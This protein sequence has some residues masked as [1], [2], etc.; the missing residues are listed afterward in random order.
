MHRGYGS[1]ACSPGR[2]WDRSPRSV[3]CRSPLRVFRQEESA[4]REARERS[5]LLRKERREE[6]RAEARCVA[7]DVSRWTG[8]EWSLR[9]RRNNVRPRQESRGQ[10]THRTGLSD[11]SADQE[12]RAPGPA[13]SDRDVPADGRGRVDEAPLLPDGGEAASDCR[14]HRGGGQPA[15]DALAATAARAG[16]SQSVNRVSSAQSNSLADTPAPAVRVSSGSVRRVS[17]GLSD[18]PE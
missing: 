8:D 2:D 6:R 17:S 16:S 13:S 1:P 11:A 18:C 3:G 10:D 14:S 15:A 4:V 12:G 5:A 7:S 9:S